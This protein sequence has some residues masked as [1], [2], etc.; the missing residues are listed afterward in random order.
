VVRILFIGDIVGRP[1]R[2]L[3]RRGV[4]PLCDYHQ[5]DLVIA[6]AENAAASCSSGAST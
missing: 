6:N 5:V 2:E 3:V 4:T 1:G